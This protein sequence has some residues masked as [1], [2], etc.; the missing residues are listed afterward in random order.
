MWGWASSEVVTWTQIFAL[1]GV[2]VMVLIVQFGAAQSP[3][4]SAKADAAV[5]EEL[6]P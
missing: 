5:E 2:L 1:L 4:P 3:S 6:L